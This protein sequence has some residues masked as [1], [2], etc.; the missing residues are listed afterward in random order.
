MKLTLQQEFSQIYPQPGWHE[1]D[2][3]E[4]VS[5][6]HNCIEGA[7][8]AFKKDGNSVDSIKAIGITNRERYCDIVFSSFILTSEQSARPP[9]FGTLSQERHFTTP[10]SGQILVLSLS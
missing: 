4:I 3:E 10:S 1:H 9:L 7:I 6:V 2:P 8:E 5:S